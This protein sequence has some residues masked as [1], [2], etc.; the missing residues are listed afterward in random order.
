MRMIETFFL[1]YV[2][3]IDSLAQLLPAVKRIENFF[4]QC[5][6]NAG[7]MGINIAHNIQAGGP[8]GRN[9]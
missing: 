6:S 7:K 3:F 4:R 9:T 5:V 8:E 2:I 1:T